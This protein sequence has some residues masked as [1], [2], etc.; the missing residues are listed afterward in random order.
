MDEMNSKELFNL[1]GKTAI[2]TGAAGL[3]GIEHARAL[4]DYGATVILTDLEDKADSVLKILKEEGYSKV[5]GLTLNVTSPD[6][7]HALLRIIMADISKDIHILVNNASLTNQSKSE[8]F[9]NSFETYPLQDWNSIM[10]VNLTGSFLGCQ[11]IGTHMLER[12]EGSIVNIASL[13]GVV[14]PNHGMYPGT[15]I[16][17]PVAYT[18]SKHAVIALTKYLATL[19]AA[20]GVR[21]NSLT[22]GG[23]FNNHEG[24]FLERF[25]KLNPIGRMAKVDEL[26]GGLIYLASAASSNVVGHNLIIDGGW[27]VW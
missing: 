4:L 9:D 17:Q 2:I 23:M 27:T 11:I 1:D 24:L 5:Y 3:L 22:P 10:E 12:K 18:V 20:D 7:W 16:K 13:Y 21:V 6:S 8:N 26:R 14:S 19:W 15:G 25:S